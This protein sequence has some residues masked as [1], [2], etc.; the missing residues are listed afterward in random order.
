MA[1]QKRSP[2]GFYPDDLS[3]SEIAESYLPDTLFVANII[4]D[5][6]EVINPFRAGR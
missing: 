3:V 5:K 6:T 4:S 2:A 1:V